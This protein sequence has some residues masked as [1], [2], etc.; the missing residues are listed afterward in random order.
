MGVAC[1]RN[2][3]EGRDMKTWKQKAK[4]VLW[5]MLGAGC[6]ILMLVAMQKKDKMLCKSISIVINGAEEKVFIDRDN[7]MDVLKQYGIQRDKSLEGIALHEV[8]MALEKNAWIASAEIFFDN[9][10]TLH[11]EVREREPVARIFT[12]Q[13]TS[14]YIDS[15][16]LRLP[17]SD[18]HTARLP[19]FTS[20]PSAKKKLSAPDSLVLDDVKTI[21]LFVAADSF[22]SRQV[23][24]V[25]ITSKRT[26]ELSMTVGNQIVAIGHAEDLDKKFYRLQEFYKQVWPVA[27]FEK[28]ERIDVQYDGQVVAVIRGAPRPLADTTDAMHQVSTVA[29]RLQAVMRDSVYVSDASKPLSKG[30]IK[31]Q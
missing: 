21:A 26:Y 15:T 3:G 13:G 16:G 6:I 14:F 4:T 7:I 8:E 30:E 9:E 2:D 24:Q 20:F 18:N 5:A 31:K 17:L 19:V 1:K 28:Y 22:W 23:A 29:H 11:A 27:G 25:N 12:Y 10:Q